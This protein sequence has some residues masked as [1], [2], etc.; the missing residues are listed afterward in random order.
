MIDEYNTMVAGVGGQGS[1]LFAHI[2]GN[3]AIAEGYQVRVAETY[4]AA[5]RGGSVLGHIRMGKSVFA[6]TIRTDKLD[7]L[8]GLEPLEG[9]RQGTKYLSADGT[10]IINTRPINPIDVNIG[11]VT[12]PDIDSIRQALESLC[13]EVIMIDGLKLALEAGSPRTLNIVMLGIASA[14]RKLPIPRNTL[15]ETIA[16]MVPIRTKEINKKAF[17]LGWNIIK[18]KNPS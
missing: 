5:M 11:N 1:I 17:T 2:L 6:P 7:L 18:N 16:R 10:A 12:Y 4:G 8:I 13:K 3:A 15:E 9:L 14:K